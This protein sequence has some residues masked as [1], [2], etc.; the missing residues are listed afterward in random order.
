[1][2]QRQWGRLHLSAYKSNKA[3]R[4]SIK[5]LLL[6]VTT[7]MAY[8]SLQIWYFKRIEGYILE[9]IL[10]GSTSLFSAMTS[11]YLRWF[12]RIMILESYAFLWL[13]CT[14]NLYNRSTIYIPLG[15]IIGGLI[16]LTLAYW[17]LYP[18]LLRALSRCR[19]SAPP[20]V[21][22]DEESQEKNRYE[23]RQN[24]CC[25]PTYICVYE[26]L[27]VNGKPDGVGTWVD[28]S[29]HGEYLT[30]YFKNGIPIGPFESIESETRSILVNL[31]IIFATNCSGRLWLTRKPLQYGVASIEACISGSFYKN[32][33]LVRMLS[34]PKVCSCEDR[35][36]CI[37]DMIKRKLYKHIDDD[38]KV[39][40]I[41]ISIDK[42]TKSLNIPGHRPVKK[43]NREVKVRLKKSNIDSQFSL[44][45]DKGWVTRGSNEGVL[46]IHGIYHSLDD[47]LKR[48]GQFLALG[49]FP[50][51]FK[52]FVFN[53]P[54]SSNP[55]LYYQAKELAYDP[56][57]HRDLRRFLLS[58]KNSGI[59]SLSVMCHS[60]GTRVLLG[61]FSVIKDIFQEKYEVVDSDDG[62]T[63]LRPSEMKSHTQRDFKAYGME[64]RNLILLNPDYELEN[65]VQE[66]EILSRYCNSITIYAD[67]RDVALKL[68]M[69]LN[70]KMKLG[71][72]T[73]PIHDDEGNMLDVDI[74]DT[75]DLDG[76]MNSQFH[77]YFN[78]NRAMIDDLRELIV[79]GM[80]Y[81]GLN[82][83]L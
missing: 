35:C 34:E 21:H 3:F 78:I 30:G 61:A 47:S 82:Y 33:P 72:H 11:S 63:F 5:M 48:F 73:L 77:G 42:Q 23:I 81:I 75:G 9:F 25:S 26:G 56:E 71:I 38:K 70:R 49:H 53:W 46:F 17:I 67:N 65:F 31:R 1:M 13:F 50:S 16:L 2:K 37:K 41:S 24:V 29:Y 74:I 79:E 45:L 64:F 44:T 32:Y 4:V 40:T 43:R 76:N 12:P 19:A 55:L 20:Q 27:L 14:F 8:L 22:I 62:E 51:S 15:T 68:S 39:Q 60:M 52:P 28:S 58:I 69:R 66:Y 83:L 80:L 10:M 54:S 6:Y 57:N 59:E 18:Y 7:Y 36:T